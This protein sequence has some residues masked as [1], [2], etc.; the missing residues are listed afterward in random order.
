MH[1]NKIAYW[2]IDENVVITDSQE[3]N[4]IS[5]K[6]NYSIHWFSVRSDFLEPNYC[7]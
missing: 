2:S 7:K 3:P 5:P 6:S 1:K 4:C